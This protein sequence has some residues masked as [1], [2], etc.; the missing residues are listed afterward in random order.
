MKEVK[1]IKEDIKL[2]Q[3]WL[4]EIEI[5]EDVIRY[6]KSERCLVGYRFDDPLSG[7][8]DIT[9]YINDELKNSIHELAKE[10][11]NQLIEDGYEKWL[12]QKEK[13]ND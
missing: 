3:E 8:V 11:L 5:L 12:E 2:K 9:T 4:K 13:Q 6:T 10:K 1:K 7:G